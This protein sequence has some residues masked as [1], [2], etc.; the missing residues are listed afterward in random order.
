MD[1]E[2][3]ESRQETEGGGRPGVVAA[4]R[5]RQP[6]QQGLGAEQ[7]RHHTHEQ[8]HDIIVG[9]IGQQIARQ[10]TQQRARYQQL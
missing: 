3:A 4:P 10:H 6:A 2:A 1:T 5:T 7:E 9:A 8:A